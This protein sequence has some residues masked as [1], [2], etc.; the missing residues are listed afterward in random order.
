MAAKKIRLHRRR[1]TRPGIKRGSVL[2]P[3]T[4]A[5]ER[6]AEQVGKL[7]DRMHRQTL[8]EVLALF[9]NHDLPTAIS[10]TVTMDASIASAGRRIFNRLEKLFGSLFDDK[11]PEIADQ[12]VSAADRQSVSTL[13]RSLREMSG[14]KSFKVNFKTAGV[15]DVFK[16][17]VAE[18]VGLIKRIP[19]EF[20]QEVQGEVMR[21]ITTGSGLQDLQP[22]MEKKYGEA[23]RHA[24]NVAMDQTR[25]AYQGL[26]RGRMR[27]VGAQKYEWM[28]SGGSNHPRE[29][30]RDTLDGQIFDIDDPPI[31]NPKTGFRGNPGDEPFCR[32]SMRPII[33][34]E[35]E[36]DE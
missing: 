4:M 16:A 29:Y 15:D 34:F 14:D 27:K 33:S 30:H 32:C 26:T 20:L 35:V 28:H 17:S 11:A 2:R 25:K 23:K 18:S 10:G 7:I 24:S 3:P 36:D 19:Q 5:G 21:S 6:M 9:D 22:Y 13:G 8:R 12:M 1:M 31:S